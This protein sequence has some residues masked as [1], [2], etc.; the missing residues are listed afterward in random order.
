V[1]SYVA[2]FLRASL[3]WLVLGTALGAGMAIQ[4]RWVVYRPAHLHAL[5][6]GFVMMMIAG[7]AYHV[8]P[9]IAM[10]ALH[11]PRLAR[12]HVSIANAG[13]VLL[14][15]GFVARPHNAGWAPVVLALGGALSAAG[16]W[17][18]A[19]NLWRTLD[20]AAPVPVVTPRPR[21]LPQR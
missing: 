1:E 9:R 5:L 12:T 20:R 15:C 14:L 17:L 19:W 21:P 7:V 11:A 3:A 16:A 6:L 10:T 13:L 4:P 2:R 8:I 18:F